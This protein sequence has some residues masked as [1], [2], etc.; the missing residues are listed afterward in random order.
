MDVNRILSNDLG[1]KCGALFAIVVGL[2]YLAPTSVIAT[3]EDVR[4]RIEAAR[5][6][7]TADPAHQEMMRRMNES[8]S[9]SFEQ[10][11]QQHHQEYERNKAM[12]RSAAIRAASSIKITPAQ[13]ALAYESQLFRATR[14][15]DIQNFFSKSYVERHI[16]TKSASEKTE[17]LRSLKAAYTYPLQG[18]TPNVS[19][20][21]VNDDGEATVRL[22]GKN[23]YNGK[24]KGVKVRL[25][26]VPEG[27]Y[28]K[29]DGYE[30]DT[31]LDILEFPH[32]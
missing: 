23:N 4:A 27:G 14:F 32:M 31:G 12:E 5:A 9:A 17:E 8:R 11:A 16:A 18:N 15:E 24:I 1:T 28:W 7:F 20:G 3:P 2:S 22:E 30:A 21:Q 19:G 26:L 10:R 29:I 25:R 13:C 6:R